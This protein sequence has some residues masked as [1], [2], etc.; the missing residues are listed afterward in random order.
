MS[1]LH[2]QFAEVVEK[3]GALLNS[4]RLFVFGRVDVWLKAGADPELDIYPVCARLAKNG[5]WSGSNL[6]YFD[7]A[8][9]QSHADRTMPAPVMTPT[10]KPGGRAYAPVA[11]L[12][13][14]LQDDLERKYADMMN[15][16][17][18]VMSVT[19]G[20]A[21]RMFL[22]GWLS[23]EAARNAGI[24]YRELDQ[25]EMQKAG[26]VETDPGQLRNTVA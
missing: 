11:P 4:P 20:M 10:P 26:S 19:A 1:S 24:P 2:P 22:K 21:K 16:G 7:R 14:E 13:P 17:M 6:S 9:M 12:S 23:Y 15:K 18:T 25:L 5:R 3:L 8:V